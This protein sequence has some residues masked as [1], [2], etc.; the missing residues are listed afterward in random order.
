M[1]RLAKMLGLRT[2]IA[3]VATVCVT[4]KLILD[5]MDRVPFRSVLDL[6]PV[7]H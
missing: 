4:V 3:P 2:D 6:Y 7:S 5:H 1:S